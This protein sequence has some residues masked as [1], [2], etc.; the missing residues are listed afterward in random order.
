MKPTHITTVGHGV[1]PE[2]RWQKHGHKGGVLWFTGLS[3]AGKSTLA[4]AL[5]KALFDK[6]FEVFTLDGD[7]LRHGLNA[8]LGFSDEDR[9]EN[10]RR[11]GEVA[12][13]FAS[14]GVLVLTAF[15][16]PF[17]EDRNRVRRLVGDGFHEVHLDP[18]LAACE[19]RD[20]K[21]LY[22]KVRAGEIQHFTGISSP[23]EAPENP[24]IRINTAEQAVEQSVA[25]LIAHV[26]NSFR[27]PPIVE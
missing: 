11:A 16:S 3:G 6:G 12:A 8:N 2:A 7:N 21:G 9:S 26:E 18:G 10:I 1:T 20:P 5:E 14:A 15:I 22:K 19:E 13:L 24:E 4:M 23:Y 27:R 17:I 25:T